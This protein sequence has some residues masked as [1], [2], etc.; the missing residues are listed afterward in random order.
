MANEKYF[1]FFNAQQVGDAT[2]GY[3]WENE[4]KG[5]NLAKAIGRG[6]VEQFKMVE[7]SPT[8]PAKTF[9]AE[10]A[11]NAVRKAY[12]DGQVSG[13]M[14]VVLSTNLETKTAV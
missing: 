13:A 10:E 2:A 5:A 11:V 6:P 12:G 4:P 3:V 1:V 7:V 9:S 8:D 14:R